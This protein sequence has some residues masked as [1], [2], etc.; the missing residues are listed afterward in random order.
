LEAENR[1]R[2]RAQEAQDY[3][4]PRG[5]R[6]GSLAR[7]AA[8][9]QAQTPLGL[10]AES[11]AAL[12]L[13][14]GK[15]IASLD[16]DSLYIIKRE[17]MNETFGPFEGQRGKYGRLPWTDARAEVTKM[18]TL[19]LMEPI[20]PDGGPV[21]YRWTPYAYAVMGKLGVKLR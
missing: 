21:R 11:N 15:S 14:I 9:F 12:D 3:N 2:K 8:V 17:M 6:R 16:R 18:V 10:D 4:V 1:A 13:Y 7:A 19:G 20:N 5:F